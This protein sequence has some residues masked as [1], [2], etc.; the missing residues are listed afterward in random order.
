MKSIA[1]SRAKFRITHVCVSGKK[2][3]QLAPF[4]RPKNCVS[5]LKMLKVINIR[6]KKIVATPQTS[7]KPLFRQDSQKSENGIAT[8]NEILNCEETRRANMAVSR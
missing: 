7:Q 3:A 4:N 1:T 5:L 6:N 8:K 2:S